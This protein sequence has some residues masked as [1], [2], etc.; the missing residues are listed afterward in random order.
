M[1]YNLGK[2]EHEINKTNFKY[3]FFVFL[4]LCKRIILFFFI[5][6]YVTH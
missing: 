6:Y 1:G 2:F 4:R 5:N 3:D